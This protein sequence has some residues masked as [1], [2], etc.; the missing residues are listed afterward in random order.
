MRRNLL[1]IL[2]GAGV[3]QGWELTAGVALHCIN[4][5]HPNSSGRALAKRRVALYLVRRNWMMLT[6]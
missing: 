5:E 3:T 2:H 1:Y 4:F 6:N